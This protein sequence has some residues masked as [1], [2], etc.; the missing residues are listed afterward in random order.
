[1]WGANCLVLPSL[2]ETFGV[3]LIEAL[4]T[5]L[6]V[7]STRSGGPEDI[8]TPEVG[9]LVEPGDV[10]G[11]ANA[12]GT[13]REAATH[14]PQALRAQ[15]IRRYGYEAVGAQLREVYQRALGAQ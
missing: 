3:V 15:A 10:P 8:V 9:V 2:L 7:I 4:A 13:M 5:G 1:M 12:L 11:L 14:D 6:P